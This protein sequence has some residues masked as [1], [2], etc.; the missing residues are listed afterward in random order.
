M[1]ST[2]RL[3]SIRWYN[4]CSLHFDTCG[5]SCSA[6]VT[7]EIVTNH[8]IAWWTHT[9]ASTRLLCRLAFITREYTNQITGGADSDWLTDIDSVMV[10]QTGDIFIGGSHD[11]QMQ[12][13]IWCAVV[14]SSWTYLGDYLMELQSIETFKMS[15]WRQNFVHITINLHTYKQATQTVFISRLIWSIQYE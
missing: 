10:C 15:L 11:V 6:S 3:W 4:T 2:D 9:T 5:V 14:K 7:G 8:Q 13:E 1:T 12:S